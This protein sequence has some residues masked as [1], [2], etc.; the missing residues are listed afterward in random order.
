MYETA[1]ADSLKSMALQGL[2]VAWVPLGDEQ[3]QVRW[4]FAY[5]AAPCGARRRCGCYGENW[6]RVCRLKANLG[7]GAMLNGALYSTPLLTLGRR[8]PMSTTQSNLR[9]LS[10]YLW[11]SVGLFALFSLS[12]VI[13]VR[14]EKGIDQANEV[15]QQSLQ[16]AE[17]L[18][19]SSDA[20]TRTARTYV[21]TGERQYR[22]EY[23][24]ILA[25]RDGLAPRPENPQASY[26]NLSSDAPLRPPAS[27]LHLMQHAGFI[28]AEMEQLGQA[29]RLSDRLSE[30]EL[31]AM[32]WRDSHLQADLTAREA[33]L[34]SLYDPAY[35]QTKRTILQQ[36]FSVQVAVHTRTLAA[37][38]DSAAYAGLLLLLLVLFG[39]LVLVTLL[40]ARRGLGRIL[41]DSVAVLYQRIE[42]LG[43]GDFSAAFA[44][45]PGRE[46]S[47]LG[48]LAKA[49]ERLALSAEQNRQAQQQV[50]ASEQRFRDIVDT[51]DGIVW[52]ADA[53]TFQF[54]FIS[55]KALRLL[56]YA[57]DDWRQPGFWVSH[58]HPEDQNWAP[59]YCASCTGRLE[60][61]DFEYRFVAKD[62]RVVWLR[63]I[64]TVVAEDGAPR[65]LRGVMVDI[66]ELK[67]A[68]QQLRIAEVAFDSQEGIMVANRAHEILRVN[69]AFSRITGYSAAEVLGQ[70]PRLLQSGRH[71]AAFYAQMWQAINTSGFWEGDI[72]NRRKNGDIYPEYLTLSAVKDA[73]GEV[74]H[75]VGIF[76]DITQR[77][78]AAEKIHQLAFY[79]AL[80]DLPNRRLLLDRLAQALLTSQRRATGGALLFIDLDNFKQLNDTWGHAL[81]DQLLQQVAQ[82]LQAAVREGD[83]VARLGGDEFVV[84]LESLSVDSLQ[85]AE[86]T[87]RVGEKI[88]AS[89]GRAYALAESRYQGTASIGAVLFA[90][91]R[92][93][94]D[95]LLRAADISMYAAKKAGRNTLCFFD[96]AMQE[97]INQRAV[98][99]AE[100]Q[101]A[102]A[103]EQFVL[104]YQAQCSASGQ[105]IGAEVLVRWVHPQR[106]LL[107]PNEFIPLAEETGL[108]LPLGHWVLRSACSQ[109]AHWQGAASTA[110]L[111]LAVN[112]SAKQFALP[113]LVDE[114][115]ALLEYSAIEPSRLKLELTESLLL[116]NTEAVISKMLA[117]KA[118]GV[119]FSMDDFGTG[120]SSLSYLKRLP[121]DQLKIDRSF[122]RDVL[123]DSNDAVI[124]KTIIVLAKSLGL[125]VIAEGVE[126][127]GQLEFLARS[128][129][130]A[131]QGYLFSRP[132]PIAEFEAFLVASPDPSE[133]RQAS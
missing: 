103:D 52:E 7:L 68:E 75:Y 127:H 70:S 1:L 41:G 133:R 120:Y 90:A 98:M 48:W 56:G 33:V 53:Q 84:M 125:Q 43:R 78:A 44:V 17:E 114:V 55:Q 101:K 22:D 47:I 34:A 87:L 77:K 110:R 107:A 80:T 86:Q 109:L 21:V 45:A 27:L 63:D 30:V 57:L 3:W 76:S 39:T 91:E 102:I 32:A 97:A 74:S 124:A 26:W 83:T 131:Y 108:I 49:Q 112:L 96:P 19:D 6:R 31:A 69:R 35:H 115:L 16:L 29:K 11:L 105:V 14:A 25:M 46:E 20:L 58:V 132:L 64:V 81:G 95:E 38:E 12:F 119:G 4:K 73:R 126:S 59:A 18:R 111:S 93:G 36:I 67:E 118:L 72:W 62:G 130:Q 28:P 104:H 61:H 128:G 2:G 123:E 37:V 129:C 99:E 71:D 113:T 89:L 116:D 92:A 54:T 15:R 5:T 79:D 122:V 106:G 13:Y 9:W 121:L 88:L 117:I 51:A 66:T 10:S 94:V 60:P 24:R 8:L 40:S 82:R 42:N 23:R 50:G 65:W 85:A 100:L